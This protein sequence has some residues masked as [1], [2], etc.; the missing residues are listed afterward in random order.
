VHD[1]SS[2]IHQVSLAVGAMPTSVDLDGYQCR[3]DDSRICCTVA[4]KGQTV[5]ASGLLQTDGARRW[6]LANDVKLCVVAP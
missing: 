1:C 6:R 3:G 2:G 5:V 4:G